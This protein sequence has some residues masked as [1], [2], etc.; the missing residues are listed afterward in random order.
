MS[1]PWENYASTAQAP[2]PWT[3]YA[4]ADVPPGPAGPEFGSDPYINALAQKHGAD[5]EVIRGLV[6]SQAGTE[7]VKGI[8]ILGGLTDKAGAGI[9]ALAAPL[10]GA[11]VPGAT[12]GDRYTKN[13]ALEKEIASDFEAAHPN[14]ATAAN[15]VGGLAS[16][17]AAAGTALGARALG[18]TA[19]TLPGQIGAGIASGGVIGGA[20]AATRGGNPIE[21]AALGAGLGG[22]IPGVARV[23][24]A[25]AAPVVSNVSARLNPSG[26]A[27]TQVARALAESGHTPQQIDAAINAAAG[28]GQGMFTAADAMGNP[29]Q[30][31]LSTVA[32]APGEGRTAVVDFLEGRQAGQGR[33]VA[34]TLAEGFDSPQTAAQTETALTQARDTAGDTQYGAARQGAGPVDLTGAIRAIDQTLTPGLTQLAHPQSAIANDSIETALQNVRNRLTDGRSNLTDF[35]AVQRVRGDLADQVQTAVRAG[36]GNR[37]RLLS[38]VLRQIDGAME[39]ASPGFLQANQNFA[40]ASRNI[41]AVGQGRTAALRGRTEDTIPAFQALPAPGQAAFRSGYVDPL[42][43]QAQGAAFG[44]NKA[45]PLTSDAFHQ[46]AGTIGAAAPVPPGSIGTVRMNG[47]DYHM[48][49]GV[50]PA[51]WPLVQPNPRD[52]MMNRLGRENTMFETRATALGGSKTADNL[53][54]QGAMGLDP[55]I[56]GHVLSGNHVGAMRGIFNAV[57]NGWN[58]NTPEVRRQVANI[59][60]TRGG[61]NRGTM[62]QVL[63][64]TVQRIQEMQHASR[65][66]GR[67]IG[68]SLS[69]QT[70]QADRQN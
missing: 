23:L 60:L 8:P 19:Q 65:A 14:V 68:L 31:M 17:G 27:A 66:I 62:Q 43:E 48:I 52:I 44:V 34:N 22:A 36:Q 16:T 13:L 39:Q 21:G 42:I 12:I 67:G 59:L 24:G 33:R 35:T 28:E 69:D 55:S 3:N 57:S 29:G 20:D 26:Y 25:V 70:N 2:G 32:R 41:E 38:G 51:R 7:G 50:A 4:G 56:I 30:R 64:D 45:R 1:G 9:S 40:Q 18:L 11:G 63:N 47:Q 46:E 10:T 61:M 53:A 15:L 6:N 5:P 37:A 49:Q 54:D 58:G